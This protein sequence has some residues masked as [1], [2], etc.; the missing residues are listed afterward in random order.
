MTTHTQAHK[1]TR[2]QTRPPELE[3]DYNRST[4]LGYESPEE[5]GFIRCLDHGYPIGS[6]ALP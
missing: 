3:S 6:L 4:A 1:T 2:H 5:A